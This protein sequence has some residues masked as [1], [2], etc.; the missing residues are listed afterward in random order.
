MQA[1]SHIKTTFSQWRLC[2]CPH[3]NFFSTF[4][5]DT[6]T[7]ILHCTIRGTL[8]E[9]HE[10]LVCKAMGNQSKTS[11]TGGWCDWAVDRAHLTDEAL[12]IGLAKLFTGRTVVGLGDGLGVYR[13]LI[14][15][16]GEV[17]TY[18][19]F[20]GSPNI[21]AITRGQVAS[22]ILPIRQFVR[23]ISFECQHEQAYE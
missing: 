12:A 15:G 8:Q 13:R 18:D 17:T 9:R 14:L 6:L 16:T 22:L 7:N 3:F 4:N 5:I 23:I 2:S 1:P 11:E 19:A 20:D 10:Q 21:H